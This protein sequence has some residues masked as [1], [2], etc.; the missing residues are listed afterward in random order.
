MPNWCS[1]D[2]SI[3][4]K[5]PEM[6][7][8]V[9]SGADNGKL[10]EEMVPIG[11]WDYGT[12]IEKWGTK[13]D[14]T[15]AETYSGDENSVNMYFMTAW[16]PPITFYEALTE[17]GFEVEATYSEEGMSF[18]GKY[19]SEGG[20]ESYELD[21]SDENWRDEIDDPDVMDIA[22]GM[23]ESYVEFNSEEDEETT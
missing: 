10:F 1:N 16:S 22:E 14:V 15:D 4:H 5:N 11:E 3:T 17:M 20:D 8:K 6:I 21:F 18:A 23:Y 2:V 9:I 13:W 19:T 12:S 7:K